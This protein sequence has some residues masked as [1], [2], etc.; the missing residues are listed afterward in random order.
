ME[1][2][3]QVVADPDETVERPMTHRA[4]NF[5]FL[6][7]V[8]ALLVVLGHAY[9]LLG[10]PAATPGLIGYGV[11]SIGVVIFF[12][13]SGYL[14]TASWNRTRDP[15]SYAAAR[16]LRI[17]PG[18]AVVVLVCACV[19]GPLLTVLPV[20]DYATHPQTTDYLNNILMKPV[21]FLPGVFT[22]LPYANVVNGSLWTLPAEFLCYIVVPLALV[23]PRLARPAVIAV[24]L[25]LS[26]WYAATP[27]MESAVVYGTR[28]SDAAVMWVF[29]AAG[30]LLRLGHER[31]SGL[32]RADVA[33]G[34]FATYLLVIAIEPTWVGHVS[35][36]ALPYLV[37]AVGLA[38]TPYIRQA[39]RFGDLSYG[40]YLWAFPVQQTVI[41][42]AGVQNMAVNLIVVTA[43]TA[44]LALISWHVVE[45]PAL[46][47]KNRVPRLAQVKVSWRGGR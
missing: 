6:R 17:F 29:F 18:L 22:D 43:L 28:I 19:L 37:L 31:V 23:V 12:S 15:L 5:D 35:W 2:E 32:F 26:L 33:V 4:N 30:V 39:A 40:I 8:G 41:H 13:I 7:L 16:C 21:Y 11:Q 9:P 47:L 44:L 46:R 27:P 24:L 20:G 3:S 10:A 34:L 1:A 14:I 42:V 36:V 45:K 38:S 25:A